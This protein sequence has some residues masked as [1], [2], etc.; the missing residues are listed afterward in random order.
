[1]CLID[2]AH[3]MGMMVLLD[4]VHSHASKN[5][6]DGLN[7]Y[8]GTDACYFHAGSKVLSRS[9]SPSLTLA[10]AII[11]CGTVDCSTTGRGRCCAFF[12]PTCDT[13]CPW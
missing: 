2:E 12:C 7:R 8:D 1:M 11:R 3:G 10:R 4:L 5:A 6:L 13:G 9:P